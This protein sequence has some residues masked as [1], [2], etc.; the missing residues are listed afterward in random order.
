M[1]HRTGFIT[2][3]VIALLSFSPTL[4]AHDDAHGP[5]VPV[6]P[7]AEALIH[8]A[9]G[10]A[11]AGVPAVAEGAELALLNLRVIDSATGEPTF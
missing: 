4:S 10:V 11:V 3:F 7:E 2:I 8:T 6:S 9:P 5:L 1:N